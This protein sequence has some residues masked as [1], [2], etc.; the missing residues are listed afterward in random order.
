[1][2]SES[3]HP[4]WRTRL[5]AL[6]FYLGAAPFFWAA[7]TRRKNAYLRHHFEQALAIFL[8]LFLLTALFAALVLLLSYTMIHQRA[9]YDQTHPEPHL[10]TFVRRLYLCW[11]VFWAYGIGLALFGSTRHMPIV[12]F[13]ASRRGL[14]GTAMA[15]FVVLYGAAALTVPVAAHAS[16]LIRTDERPG[17]VLLLYED[18]GKFPRFLFALGFYNI[19][20]T[21][22]ARWGD[23]SVVALRLT[24]EAIQRA[25]KEGRFVFIGSHGRAQ[26]LLLKTGYV[27]PE[28]VKAMGAKSQLQYVYLTSCD[29]GAQKEAWEDAFAP[30][31]VITYDRYTAVVE[32]AWWLWFR[33]P[34]TIRALPEPAVKE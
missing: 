1:M 7:R 6:S 22:N 14:R 34:A 10:L 5:A 9:L 13:I 33:A 21:A 12:A 16:L 20:R 18:I 8:L 3:E 26:G 11:L 24:E 28:D 29:S 2:S 4:I 17:E 25:V 32:H 19:S 23:G 27:S 31:E 15:V 30:A